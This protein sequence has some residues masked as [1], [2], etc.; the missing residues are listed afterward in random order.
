MI[1]EAL[2]NFQITPN[3]TENIMREIARLKPVAPS[4]GKPLVPWAIGVSAVAIVLLMLGFSHQH[5][6]RFQKPYSFNAASEMK[7]ELIDAPVVRNLEAEPDDRTQLGNANAQGGNNGV[8]NQV[9]DAASFDLETLIT[10]MK[11]YDNAVTSVTGDFILERQNSLGIS[12]TEY[13]LTFEGEK[14]RM[15]QGQ[16][17]PSVELWDGKRHWEAREDRRIIFEFEIAPGKEKTDIETI[18]QAF[19]HNGIDLA[20]DV[21]IVDG[22]EPEDFTLIENETDQKYYFWLEGETRLWVYDL[23]HLEYGVR[24]QWAGSP[25]NDP[26]FWLTFCPASNNSYLSEPLW[27]LLEKHESEIIGN[28]ILNG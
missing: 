14:V 3:L 1:R 7:V 11:Q 9:N 5:L 27:H 22:D 17:R 26:R 6:S 24:P 23:N 2:E 8:G 10:K 16:D 18:R 21:S 28:E 12:K 20:D 4:G 19:K 15:D 25:D 13:T